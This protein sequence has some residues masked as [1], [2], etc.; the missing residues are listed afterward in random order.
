MRDHQSHILR[1][2]LSSCFP[3]DWC[4]SLSNPHRQPIWRRTVESSYWCSAM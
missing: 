4:R 2:N 1:L 3:I